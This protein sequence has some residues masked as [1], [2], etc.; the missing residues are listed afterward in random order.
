M[1]IIKDYPK[2]EECGL[3]LLKVTHAHSII[4]TP[5]VGVSEKVLKFYVKV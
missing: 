4:W 1:V 2:F 3:S 5:R